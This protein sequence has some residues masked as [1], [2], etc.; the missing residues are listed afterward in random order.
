M[1]KVVSVVAAVITP[2]SPDTAPHAPLGPNTAVLLSQ[3]PQGKHLA[4]TWEFPGGQVEPGESH[5]QALSRELEEELGIQVHSAQPWTTITHAYPN[6]TVILN[7]Y[8]VTDWSGVAS[9]HEGQAIEWVAWSQVGD[10]PMPE[11][12]R[13]LTRA[14][15]MSP[16]GLTLSMPSSVQDAL[17]NCRERLA[18]IAQSAW[19][20]HPWWIHLVLGHE[21][22]RQNQTALASLI[23]L[24]KDHGHVAMIDGPLSLAA[25]LKA[26]GVYLS[27][28]AGLALTE[29]PD[30]L[31]WVA[32]ACD[33]RQT[34]ARAGDLGLD[35][36]TLAPLRRPHRSA[37]TAGLGG[38][39][40]KQLLAHASLP[41]LALGGL[42]LN[43]LTWVRSLGGFGIASTTGF[44]FDTGS[45]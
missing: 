21:A 25:E 22:G 38:D 42:G 27:R 41:V 40:F 5:E 43:D 45:S 16:F 26:D 18:W 44:V 30:G 11:A 39:Q 33:D 6:K 15:G 1:T 31:E 9:G 24:I 2:Q 14:F 4:G 19:A 12:D 8:R 28:Q 13:A 34:L 37:D 35:Y 10:R 36:V 29:R 3:R 32:M 7:I 20:D 23:A 17:G